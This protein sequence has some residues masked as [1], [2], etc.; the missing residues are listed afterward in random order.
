MKKVPP[1]VN[2]K[3][4]DCGVY[5]CF[6]QQRGYKKTARKYCTKCDRDHGGKKW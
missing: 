1:A 2:W 6:F 5:T 4:D 3:C